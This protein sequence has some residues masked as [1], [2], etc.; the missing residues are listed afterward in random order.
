[1]TKGSKGGVRNG[2]RKGNETKDQFR[3][4]LQKEGRWDDYVKERDRVVEQQGGISTTQAHNIIYDKYA[5]GAVVDDTVG[6]AVEDMFPNQLPNGCPLFD[7]V[8]WK[9]K[10]TTNLLDDVQ[11]VASH[12]GLKDFDYVKRSP[13]L[14]ACTLYWEARYTLAGM[15]RYQELLR[16]LEVPDKATLKELNRRKDDGSEL[17]RLEDFLVNYEKHETEQTTEQ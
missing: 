1:M 4:R 7:E 14:R 16:Q 12:L 15:Q 3:S 2:P 11:W 8:L 10:P 17:E 9:G 6:D 13:S 5:P